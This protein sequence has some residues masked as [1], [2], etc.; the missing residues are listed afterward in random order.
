MPLAL[1]RGTGQAIHVSRLPGGSD[2]RSGGPCAT[3]RYCVTPGRDVR[4]AMC[5]VIAELLVAPRSLVGAWAR[6]LPGD[7]GVRC[8]CSP[9]PAA[10]ITGARADDNPSPSPPVRRMRSR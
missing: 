4:R 10:V 3:R 6:C 7:R 8:G 5:A 9:M 2:R 1:A